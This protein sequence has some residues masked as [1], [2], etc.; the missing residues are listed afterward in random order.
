[1]VVQV[2]E[3]SG[4]V[5]AL[6]EPNHVQAACRGVVFVPHGV[7]PTGV[8]AVVKRAFD[9]VVAASL[10]L[11]LTPL[12]AATAILVRV[13]SPGP[14]LIR[15]LRIGRDLRPFYMHKFRSMVADAEQRLELL[16]HLNE[17][18]APLFKIRRDPRL[19]RVGAALRRSSL[20]ELP[21]LWNVLR[22]QM[23]LVGP[24]P[25]FGHEVEQDFLRQRIRLRVRPG[26]TGLWQISG[27][28][29]LNYD[30]MV[31]L[32]IRY[33]RRW[34]L[35]TDLRILARTLPVVLVGRGAY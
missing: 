15:Q 35:L 28:S 33:V 19:T 12:I 22:G 8:R 2:R 21:Q 6:P 16:S 25:P 3:R 18:Q 17:A 34:S 29:D 27:R 13:D 11:A 4:S 9:V 24:R 10:L 26:M 31:R 20:D 14:I 5:G 1:V 32:D 7:A 30:Q 23:S